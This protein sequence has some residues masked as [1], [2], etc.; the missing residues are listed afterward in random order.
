MEDHR[1]KIYEEEVPRTHVDA[2][3]MQKQQNAK[4]CTVHRCMICSLHHI[5][6]DYQI[7]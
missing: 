7:R 2:T 4:N 1:L 3:D 6:L 5:L